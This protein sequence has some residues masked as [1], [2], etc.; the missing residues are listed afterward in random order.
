MGGGALHAAVVALVEP[1]ASSRAHCGALG[2]AITAVHMLF[3]VLLLRRVVV[4]A[5]TAVQML[6]LV[7]LLRRVVVIARY[8]CSPDAIPQ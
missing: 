7:L 6:F 5:I 1:L 8:Y 3:L 4:I 2:V